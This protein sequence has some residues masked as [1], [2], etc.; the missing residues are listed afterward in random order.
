V[1]ATSSGGGAAPGRVA[2]VCGVAVVLLC[3]FAHLALLSRIIAESTPTVDEVAHLPAGY[4]Y[5]DRGTFRLYRHSPP[6]ARL[7][8][9]AVAQHDRPAIPYDRSWVRD[10]PAN[11][12]RFAF[13]TQ[14]ANAGTTAAQQRYLAAFTHARRATALWSAVTIPV[15]FAWGWWWFGPAA[16][17]LAAALWALCPNVL[18]HAGLVTTDLPAASAGLWACFAFALWLARPTWSRAAAAGALLGVAQLVKFSS[19]ALYPVFVV[20]F[21]ASLRRRG[22]RAPLS[23]RKVLAQGVGLLL[24]SVLVIDAGYLFERVGEP[25][26]G[27]PFLSRVLTR[28]RRPGDVPPPATTDPL[29][30]TVRGQRVNRFAGTWVGGVPS[31]LPYHLVAGFDEQKFEAEGWYPMYLRGRFAEPVPPPG[32]AAGGAPAPPRRGWWY[33]YLYALALKVPIG[34]WVL[35]CAAAVLALVRP[36]KAPLLPIAALAAVPVAAVS[37]LTDLNLGLRYVLPALPFVFLLAGSLVASGRP[38]WCTG[39]A[40]VALLANLVSVARVHPLELSYFNA[41]AGG[42]LRARWHLIDS[43]LDWGQDLRRFARWLDAHPDWEREVRL[44]YMGHVSPEFEGLRR[45]RLPPRDLRAVPDARL[46]PGEER[47]RPDTWGPLPGKYAISVN[48][49]RGMPFRTPAP[50]AEL[51]AIAVSR[52]GA[53]VGGSQM[54]DMPRGALA[55]FQH[56]TPRIDPSVGPSILLYDVSLA[57]ANRARGAIGLSPLGNP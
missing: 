44:G 11:H 15:L 53:L 18:A 21:L 25:L 1:S 57:E 34:T 27:F 12:W 37:G 7:L 32:T 33:Y 8:A 26:G 20:W 5:G 28:P 2:A 43:N 38:R 4:S 14:L 46:L 42:P 39:L 51:A 45:Y 16:G 36:L 24:A 35:A 6:L 23:S 49:E 17:A 50:L 31:P 29:Y 30:R 47:L 3:V 10:E 55:Y 19:L 56:L 54:I 22:G 52:P 41:L 9:A 48:F 13:E 40:L